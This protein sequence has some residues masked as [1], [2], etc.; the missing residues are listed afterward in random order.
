MI[1]K[2][3][4]RISFSKAALCIERQIRAM[5]PWP[6]AYTTMD[7]KQ[8]K[9]WA[10]KAMEEQSDAAFG[11]VLTVQKDYFTV[12]CGEGYL[13]I[14]ELQLEGKKRMGAGDFLRGV[15]LEP[16]DRLG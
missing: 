2:E 4:G 16:G 1:S 6:S 11:T 10:A 12:A 15:K 8:L 14:F 7:G 3:E 13:K 5:N 9:I